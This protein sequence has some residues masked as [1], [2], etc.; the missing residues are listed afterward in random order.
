MVTVNAIND[1]PVAIDNFAHTEMNQEVTVSVL[2]NDSDV[3]NDLLTITNVQ[4]LSGGT[5]DITLSGTAITATP[6]FSSEDS[7]NI[8]YT[9]SDGNGGISTAQLNVG[10]ADLITPQHGIA[11]MYISSGTFTMGSPT[12]ETGRATQVG[13]ETQHQVT[14]TKDFY[15]GKYEVTQ[16]QWE[17]V[18]NG[19]WP[20]PDLEPS[21]YNYGQSP[22]HPAYFISWNDINKV[23]GFLDKI[24]EASGCDISNLPSDDNRYHPANVPSGC[25]RLPTDAEWEYAARAG[26][27]TRYSFG[28]D[29]DGSLIDDYAWYKDNS[30]S[31]PSSHSDYGSHTGGLKQSNP[32]G[33]YD[34]YGN[35][36]EWVYDKLNMFSSSSQTDPVFPTDHTVTSNDYGKR[37][38]SQW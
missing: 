27:T 3:D 36:G 20:D 21:D 29:L 38:L 9:I 22:S 28:D 34:M 10:I 24:N 18:M 19:A 17:A 8:I 26:T 11:M 13:W 2:D 23:G 30:Y 12:D 35:V 31:L 15:M 25:F 32:W 5:A 14:I 4:V 1:T 6:Y 37:I 33:L 7:I 16:G